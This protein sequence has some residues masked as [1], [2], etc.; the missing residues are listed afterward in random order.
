MKKSIYYSLRK[1]LGTNADF[2]LIVGQRGNG[3]TYSCLKFALDEYKRTK[4]RFCYLR[5]WAEDIKAF[6]ME[7]LFAPFVDYIKEIFGEEFTITYYR[8]K[9]YL[10][11]G[12]GTK[13][14]TLGYV[15]SLSDVSHSKSIA[16]ANLK[17][18]IFDEFIQM[19]GERQMGNNEI[20]RFENVLSSLIRGD[21]TD[22][23]IFMLANTVSKFS[24][25]FIHFGID[26]N[27][28]EQGQ[29]ITKD[30][31]V[32]E[33]SKIFLRVALEYCEYN[34]EVEKKISK[35]T[36]SKM[37]R[38]GKWEIPPTDDIPAAIGEIAT[39]KLLF[40]IYED[41]ANVI[42]G[43]FLRRSKWSTIE[44]NEA[45]MLMY[46]KYHHREFLVLRTIERKS[47]Y[48]HLSEEKSLN[49]HTYNDINLMLEDIKE[50]CDI[51]FEHELYMGRVF[52]DNMFTADY[53]NNSWLRFGRVT[54]RS[55]L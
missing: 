23:K 38:G 42:I 29:I 18:I 31:P 10:V 53:F 39:E 44:Q 33:D 27:K 6:R 55:L 2:F 37:I 40:S 19:A 24:P 22:V 11:N 13:I 15:T 12:N 21:N 1:I 14:D 20:G 49:Y 43:C 54:A 17:Y 47:N 50:N 30:L 48:F 9:F 26:I 28:V 35:Y 41:Q 25:Y 36:T 3:K 52:C 16:Y 45:T 34:P 32:A 5:R 46:E 8:H 51:D 4:K 7:Q